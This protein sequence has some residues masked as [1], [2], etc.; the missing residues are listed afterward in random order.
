[1]LPVGST[2]GL[3]MF[4][5]VRMRNF[6]RALAMSVAKGVTVEVPMLS[7]VVRQNVK[8]NDMFQ[9]I[10]SLHAHRIK[11]AQLRFYLASCNKVSDM[12][13]DWAYCEVSHAVLP[14]LATL[15]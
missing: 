15:A 5:K 11:D 9:K 6:R 14:L 4:G 1:M 13:S 8:N 2:R 3:W 7:I 10:C 12:P